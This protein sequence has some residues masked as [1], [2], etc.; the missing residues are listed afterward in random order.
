MSI[1]TNDYDIIHRIVYEDVVLSKSIFYMLYFGNYMR[2][3]MKQFLLY[4]V[5]A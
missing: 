1:V 5:A 3:Y 4:K 2:Q